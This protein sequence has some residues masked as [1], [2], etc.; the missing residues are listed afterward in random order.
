MPNAS[1]FDFFPARA[2]P[3]GMEEL[4]RAVSLEN[5]LLSQ[6]P[7]PFV[8]PEAI[9]LA[10]LHWF[11][12]GRQLSSVQWRDIAGRVRGQRDTLDHS[13]LRQGAQQLGVRALLGRR[14]Q[15]PLSPG[16]LYSALRS[17]QIRM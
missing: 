4:A 10:K 5:G 2:F 12:I 16:P 8:T 13:Y 6:A 7:T 15:L 14:A 9:L 1:K 11:Q 17:P 3:L